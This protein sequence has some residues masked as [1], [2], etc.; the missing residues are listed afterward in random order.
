[1]RQP[2]ILE[3]AD[4]PRALGVLPRMLLARKPTL[5]PGDATV[6]RI[7]A[8]CAGVMPD[9][10]TLK[11][12]REVCGFAAGEHLPITIP[13]ILAHPLHM[14]IVTHPAFPL[15]LLG[16]VHVRNS[17][18]QYRPLRANELLDWQC[19]IEGHTD[20]ERGQEFELR[21]YARAGDELVWEECSTM[22]ARRRSGGG[23]KRDKAAPDPGPAGA[24]LTSFA[25]P[26]DIGRRYARV[27]GDF[28]PIHLTALT[29]RA[30]GFPKAIA[31]GM[32]SLARVAAELEAQWP[33]GKLRFEAAFKLPILLPA[34]VM[35]MSAPR[36]GGV[37]F[38]LRDDAGQKPHVVGRVEPLF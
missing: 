31:H 6:P 21:T 27:S 36:D 22:L 16:L 23:G 34:W 19:V 8:R 4:M 25:A 17:I 10:A 29:A 35:L 3:F 20:T 7:E 18:V 11:A 24:Q 1:M 33:E 28:N 32:W 5:L 26:A 2:V 13:H 30:F 12:Y 14:E 9:R 15:A 37:D 38:Q